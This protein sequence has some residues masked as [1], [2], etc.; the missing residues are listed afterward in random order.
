M[1]K[2]SLTLIF[3]TLM[4]IIAIMCL[5]AVIYKFYAQ[6]KITQT[7]I[8]SDIKEVP[9]FEIGVYSVSWHDI[10][11]LTEDKAI[12]LGITNIPYGQSVLIYEYDA[13]ITIGASE[14]P[15]PEINGDIITFRMD[16]IVCQVI[17]CELKNFNYVNSF[18][19]GLAERTTL[20]TTIFDDLNDNYNKALDVA[21]TPQRDIEARKNFMEQFSK[22]YSAIG[23]KVEWI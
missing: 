12:N 5:G 23:F 13:S 21:W 17:H 15:A 4:L 6:P 14:M 9:I 11:I 7:S 2:G 1:K 19:N 22:F 10:S 18:S 3:W 8:I 16:E 20:Y